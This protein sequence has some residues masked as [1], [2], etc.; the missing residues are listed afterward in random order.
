M[1]WTPKSRPP[2]ERMTKAYA[3]IK[4]GDKVNTVTLAEVFEVDRRTIQRDLEFLRD[5]MELPI[6]YDEKKFG[7]VID[8]DVKLPWW[9]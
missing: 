1:S 2:I 6:R 4:R 8:K 7:W 5:R 9:V 3:M